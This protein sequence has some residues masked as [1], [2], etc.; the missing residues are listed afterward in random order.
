MCVLVY[1]LGTTKQRSLEPTSN[2]VS[3]WRH[4]FECSEK[5]ALSQNGIDFIASVTLWIEGMEKSRKKLQRMG[6]QQ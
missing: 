1:C 2:P 6:S 5:K 3:R 4:L